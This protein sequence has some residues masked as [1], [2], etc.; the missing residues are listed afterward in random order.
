MTTP[1]DAVIVLNRA[2]DQMGDVLASIHEGHLSK[3]TPCNDWDV[4]QLISHVL[5]TPGHFLE[6]SRG[7]Q[8]DWSATPPVVEDEWASEFRSSADDLI[9][10]WHQQGDAADAGQV[11]WQTAEM[12]VHTW[13]LVRATEM[14]IG[15]DP[16][17]AERGLAFMSQGLTEDNR[18]KAFGPA[19]EVADDAPIYERLVAFAGRDPN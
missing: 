11:D 1:N 2:L 18:G 4:R 13:D 17:V 14:R 10:F 6:M 3:P 5:A 7:E 15:L 12:A 19:V 9:H 16:E 8:P